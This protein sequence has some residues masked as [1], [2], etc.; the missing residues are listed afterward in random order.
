MVAT[1]NKNAWPV[2]LLA[3]AASAAGADKGPVYLHPERAGIDYQLQGE[4]AGVVSAPAGQMRLG[5]QLVA[6]GRGEFLAA[7]YRGGLP[8][9]GAVANEPISVPARRTGRSVRFHT[10]Y[11][12]FFVLAGRMRVSL[13]RDGRLIGVLPRAVR[14]SPTLGMAPPPGAKVLFGG[15]GTEA[16]KNARVSPEG[17]LMQGAETRDPLPQDFLLHVEFR[18]PFMPLA[19][20]QARANSGLYLHRRYEVQVLDSFGL[21]PQYNHCGALYRYRAPLL[22]MCLPPL[23]WQTYDV[24]FHS[25][26]WSPDGKRKLAPARITV[27]LNGVTIHRNLVLTRKT[28]AGRPEGPQPLPLWLQDHGDEVRFRNVWLLPLPSRTARESRRLHAR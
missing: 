22:N 26:R 7:I 1:L 15:R 14:T 16:W 13:R 23:Q 18:L 25:P 4:Y 11:L 19:R 24:R 10:R 12:D 9:S 5:V 17:W 20:G 27:R 28:G 2:L 8:G 6:L 21:K 3:L